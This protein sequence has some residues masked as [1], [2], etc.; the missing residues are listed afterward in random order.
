VLTQSREDL[1]RR[2][3]DSL[4]G[5][6]RATVHLYNAVSPLFRRV[7]FNADRA[8][9]IALA[10]QGVRLIRRLADERPDTDWRFQYSP[11]TFS[12]TEPEFA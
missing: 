3:F 4:E 7:V 8:E 2:T 6:P 11:E 5:V 10:T 12:A 9:T 1:I